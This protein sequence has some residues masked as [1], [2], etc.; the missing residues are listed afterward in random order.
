MGNRLRRGVQTSNVG[1]AQEHEHAALVQSRHLSGEG[2]VGRA[3]AGGAFLSH[4]GMFLACRNCDEGAPSQ[5]LIILL[6]AF[7]HPHV[8]LQSRIVRFLALVIS[9]ESLE[10][11]AACSGFSAL[12]Q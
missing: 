8:H 12:D 2:W 6:F 9:T 1:Q 11:R 5:R 7:D 3:A 4:Q 10:L